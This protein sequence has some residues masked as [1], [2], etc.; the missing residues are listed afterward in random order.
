[1]FWYRKESFTDLE[2]ICWYTRIFVFIVIIVHIYEA[3]CNIS[4]S[5]WNNN[6]YNSVFSEAGKTDKWDNEGKRHLDMKNKFDGKEG[7]N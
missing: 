4:I 1:M 7:Y 3:W 5:K 6:K 2:G